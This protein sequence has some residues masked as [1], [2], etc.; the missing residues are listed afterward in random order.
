MICALG[1]TLRKLNGALEKIENLEK[2]FPPGLQIQT[3]TELLMLMQGESIRRMDLDEASTV[4]DDQ[5]ALDSK[6]DSQMVKNDIES[7]AESES[8]FEVSV[9]LGPPRDEL[10]TACN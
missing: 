7:P 5:E 2:I 10:I 4:I 1:K 9:N 3:T 6:G 8:E